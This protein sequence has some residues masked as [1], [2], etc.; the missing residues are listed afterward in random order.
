[1]TAEEKL[2]KF[3]NAIDAPFSESEL[4][5]DSEPL[6]ITLPRAI[7]TR[8]KCSYKRSQCPE[9]YDVFNDDWC[10][11]PKGDMF[12]VLYNWFI[13]AGDLGDYLYC[14]RG[15]WFDGNTFLPAHIEACRRSGLINANINF[16]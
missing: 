8:Y 14:I 11:S 9:G 1:M 15:D 6:A 7:D 4:L 12:N 3:L 16:L 5:E 13:L 10:L 2:Q